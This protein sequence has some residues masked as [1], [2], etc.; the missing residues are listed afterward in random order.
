[1]G[2]GN[3]GSDKGTQ[4]RVFTVLNGAPFRKNYYGRGGPHEDVRIYKRRYS[5]GGYI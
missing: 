2:D 4:V 3:H 5:G 1:M